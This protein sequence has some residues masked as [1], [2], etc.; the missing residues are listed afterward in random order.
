MPALS[1]ITTSPTLTFDALV[2]GEEGKDLS[3]SYDG[4]FSPAVA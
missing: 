1:Q 4:L 2:A 3:T